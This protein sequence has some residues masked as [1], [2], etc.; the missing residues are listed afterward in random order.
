MTM[1]EHP[2]IKAVADMA[3]VSTATVS[4]AL[5]RPEKVREDTRRRV[6]EAVAAIGFV[7]NDQA[8]AFRRR[9][10]HTVILLVRDI[11]NPFYLDIYKG[12]EE[13]AFAA[14]YKVLMGDARDDDRRIRHY[15]DAVRERHADGLILMIGRLPDSLRNDR[16]PPLVVALEAIAG[17]DLPTVRVD[18]A[19]AAFEAVTHL[20]QLGHRRIVHITGPLGEHL[21]T[22]RLEGYRRALEQAGIAYDPDLVV[23]G[24]FSLSAGR[25]LTLGLLDRGRRFTALFAASDQMALGAIGALK[26][27]GIQ[28]PRDVSVVGFD[29]TLVA[30]MLDPP[31]TTIHQPRREIGQAAMALMIRQLKKSRSAPVPQHCF[32]T[33]LVIR[34]STAPCHDP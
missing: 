17:L 6:L 20:L 16:L 32:P 31:L 15:I 13:A 18:N 25:A 14:G 29:D 10:S 19:A 30:G 3:G 8:R 33:R 24:D 7:P 27:H 9:A 11:S 22:A 1:A 4:R 23:E 12:V 34:S 26:S 21:G 2:N 28:V 5:S